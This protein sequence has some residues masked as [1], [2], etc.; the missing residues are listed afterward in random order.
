M[1]TRVNSEFSALARRNE[2]SDGTTAVVAV[3]NNR[4]ITVANSTRISLE[5]RT[6][7]L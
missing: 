1:C 7:S 2:L 6:N 5:S 4:K 3:I